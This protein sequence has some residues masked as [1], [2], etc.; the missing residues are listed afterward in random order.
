MHVVLPTPSVHSQFHSTH[1][2]VEHGG[3]LSP[4]K[5]AA[6]MAAQPGNRQYQRWRVKYSRACGG[7]LVPIAGGQTVS[8]STQY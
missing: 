5:L 4:L 7:N 3:G 2:G 6:G 1:T 8:H